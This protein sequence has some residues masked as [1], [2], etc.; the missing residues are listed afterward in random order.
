MLAVQALVPALLVS[1]GESFLPLHCRP[2]T[3]RLRTRTN[4]MT[5]SAAA[6]KD[7]PPSNDGSFSFVEGSD[8]YESE[9]EEILG[10][11]GDPFFLDEDESQGKMSEATKD[12]VAKEGI[13]EWEWDGEVDE[14][15][16][17]D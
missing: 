8:F 14:D 10:M 11:G 16:Y 5:A 12:P 3:F 17:F 6:K 13:G 4:G 15:A 1:L 9:R 7:E 2:T